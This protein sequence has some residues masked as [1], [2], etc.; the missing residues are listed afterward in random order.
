VGCFVRTLAI[1]LL[2]ARA[3]SRYDRSAPVDV[4]RLVTEADWDQLPQFTQRPQDA[5]PL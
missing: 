1:A 3:A 4:D 5:I 2:A